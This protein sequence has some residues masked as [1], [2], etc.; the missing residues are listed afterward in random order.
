MN[1]A[2]I[3]TVMRIMPA[4]IN[5]V[6]RRPTRRTLKMMSS[7]NRRH[8][9]AAA[10]KTGRRQPLFLGGGGGIDSSLVSKVQSDIALLAASDEPIRSPR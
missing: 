1:K 7:R 5:R 10:A 4:F 3:A 8:K 6:S 9:I 2:R